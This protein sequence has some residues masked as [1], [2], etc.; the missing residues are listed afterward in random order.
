MRYHEYKLHKKSESLLT[1]L[2]DNIFTIEL[3]TT[4]T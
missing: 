2:V 3:T 4:T 1:A